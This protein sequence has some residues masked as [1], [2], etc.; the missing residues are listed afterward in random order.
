[1][2]SAARAAGTALPVDRLETLLKYSTTDLGLP[3]QFQG[4]G[5]LA[6]AQLPAAEANAAANTLPTRPDPDVNGTYV[7]TVAGTLRETWC[8]TLV[9]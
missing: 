4:Y 5:A 6:L 7:E 3:P 2:I 8:G 1:V 9:A